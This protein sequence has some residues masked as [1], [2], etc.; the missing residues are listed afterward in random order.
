M[1]SEKKVLLPLWRIHAGSRA[2]V[3]GK[4]V[5]LQLDIRDRVWFVSALC[6]PIH[7]GWR[8]APGWVSC[9][10]IAFD[11]L[12]FLD[13]LDIRERALQ[14]V[15]ILCCCGPALLQVGEV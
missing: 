5:L 14:F 7:G 4:L 15:G 11:N 12:A 3:F 2:L 8:R 10:A 6:E 9:R 1:Y 13:K